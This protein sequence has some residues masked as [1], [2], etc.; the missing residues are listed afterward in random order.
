MDGW[1]LGY[2]VEVEL[3]QYGVDVYQG[4]CMMRLCYCCEWMQ[5]LKSYDHSGANTFRGVQTQ[6]S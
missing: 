2:K 5:T 4:E 1:G 3:A 6:R